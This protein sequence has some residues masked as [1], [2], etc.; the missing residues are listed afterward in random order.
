VG[1]G[2]GDVRAAGCSDS[3]F[4]PRNVAAAGNGCSLVTWRWPSAIREGTAAKGAEGPRPWGT[5]LKSV[6]I[7]MV[8]G[9]AV[10]EGVGEQIRA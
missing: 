10:A 4:S 9:G 8:V 3:L 5:R 1:R 2:R 6:L 7:A